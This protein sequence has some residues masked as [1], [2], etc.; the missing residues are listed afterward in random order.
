MGIHDS[1]ENMSTIRK[2]ALVLLVA[3]PLWTGCAS[4]P[5]HAAPCDGRFVPINSSVPIAA[6]AGARHERSQP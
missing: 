6:S 5:L 4:D 2:I 1:E 3:S